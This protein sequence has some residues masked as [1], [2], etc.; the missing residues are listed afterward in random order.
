MLKT[1]SIEI[2]TNCEI[3]FKKKKKIWLELL[4][5]RDNFHSNGT[6]RLVETQDAMLNDLEDLVTH[7]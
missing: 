4:S 5:G 7:E 3:L 2:I 6:L 1:S